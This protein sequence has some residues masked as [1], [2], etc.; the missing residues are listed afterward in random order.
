MGEYLSIPRSRNE[1][2]AG[3]LSASGRT[4]VT[5]PGAE[6]TK[7]TWAPKLWS[8]GARSWATRNVKSPS[9]TGTESPIWNQRSSILAQAPPRWPGSMAILTPLRGN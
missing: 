4:V 5:G 7:V 8:R 6:R 9:T 1:V 3:S 2:S